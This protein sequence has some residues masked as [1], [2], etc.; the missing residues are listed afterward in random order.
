[1]Q[2][3]YFVQMQGSMEGLVLI[4][5]F[6][7]T[8]NSEYVAKKIAKKEH[9]RV[10]SIPK[11][12]ANKEYV[13]QLKE[14][15]KV[16]FIMPVYFGGLPSI[17]LYFLENLELLNIRGTYFY[18][19]LTC[20]ENTGE[21]SAQLNKTIQKKGYTLSARYG[22][23]MVGNYVPLYRMPNAIDAKKKL[24]ESEKQIEVVCKAI[25]NCAYGDQNTVKG[26]MA[27]QFTNFAYPMYAHGR[28]T[29]HFKLTEDC[30]GC[31]LCE[32]I[33]PCQAIELQGNRP[34]W[35]RKRCV[36]CMGCLHQCPK[37]AIRYKK[38]T[39][40]KG[41]YYNPHVERKDAINEA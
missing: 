35:K 33:C 37:M 17:I 23:V 7:A 22:I 16:G 15:E 18:H 24:D 39:E 9:D 3:N 27:R 28:K 4:F 19:V 38:V 41:R 13:Y 32:R 30:S 2:Y 29:K 12:I 11:A 34:A 40:N 8:G 6:S 10:I 36:Y 20:G 26:L 31:G 5:Y 14:H 25:H 1:M 21:A